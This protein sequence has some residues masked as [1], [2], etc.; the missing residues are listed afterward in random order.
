M[1]LV[2]NINKSFWKVL[3]R[4]SKWLLVDFLLIR[5]LLKQLFG[6]YIFSVLLCCIFKFAGTMKINKTNNITNKIG[7]QS[8]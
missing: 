4:L 3:S 8:I 6:D 1:R 5:Q 7:V 2:C